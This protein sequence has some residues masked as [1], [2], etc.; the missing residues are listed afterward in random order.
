MT[1]D[2]NI[3]HDLKDLKRKMTALEQQVYPQAVV[4]TINRTAQSTKVASAKHIAPQMNSTQSGVK[5]RIDIIRANS[6][7]LWATLTAKGKDIPLIEFVIGGKKPT[8]QQGGK[9]GVVKAKV[10]GKIR[11][12]PNAF[13]APKRSGDNKTTVYER[14]GKAR[15]PVFM[16]MGP[17]IS[18]LF[19]K[20]SNEEVMQ[21]KVKERF[22]IEFAQ[23][24]K[25]Y[26]NK[27]KR[28]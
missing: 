21:A 6:K 14:K 18:R 27:L 17:G 4:R 24:L 11:T 19:R 3:Q 12:Y 2:I 1:F 9:R 5:R 25:F 16:R 22:P 26:L 28:R 8:Q 7:R 15:K 20:Q 10:F 23:N 13:I